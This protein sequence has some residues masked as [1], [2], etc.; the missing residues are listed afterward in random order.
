MDMDKKD[1]D[2]K[3]E[4]KVLDKEKLAKNVEFLYSRGTGKTTAMLARAIQCSYG[5]EENVAVIAHSLDMAKWLAIGTVKL[6]E[7]L[8]YTIECQEKYRVQL[9]GGGIIIFETVDGM[10]RLSDFS[11]KETLV[12]HGCID[13]LLDMRHRKKNRLAS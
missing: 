8:G 11:V 2:T 13:L 3:E 7:E 10:E 6:A 9:Q 5:D 4:G 12:D 1:M